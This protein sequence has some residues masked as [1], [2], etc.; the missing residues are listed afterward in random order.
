MDTNKEDPEELMIGQIV[1]GVCDVVP[2]KGQDYFERLRFG[3]YLDASEYLKD[4]NRTG[5]GKG[6]VVYFNKESGNYQLK[7][8]KSLKWYESWN[9]L[10]SRLL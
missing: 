1:S 3:T 5:R 10:R 7:D 8:W 2:D 4:L 6:K 9:I